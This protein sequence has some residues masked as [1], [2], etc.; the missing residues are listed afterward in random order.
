MERYKNSR[1]FLCTTGFL[2]TLLKKAIPSVSTTFVSVCTLSTYTTTNTF[3]ML[4][5]SLFRQICL[6]TFCFL[7]RFGAL[8]ALHLE[9][10]CKYYDAHISSHVNDPERQTAVVINQ[11]WSCF[12]YCIV[13]KYFA[14]KK[15][16]HNLPLLKGFK[17]CTKLDN[18]LEKQASMPKYKI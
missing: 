14:N 1:S 8:F 15:V 13:S 7:C 10:I 2:S 17:A 3:A 4:E 9:S 5:S 11:Y 6:S 16:I 12:K 18:S